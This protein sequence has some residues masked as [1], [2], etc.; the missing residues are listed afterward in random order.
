MTPVVT[1]CESEPPQCWHHDKLSAIAQ[2]RLFK[3]PT[4]LQ[5]AMVL[6]PGIPAKDQWLIVWTVHLQSGM[7]MKFI[8]NRASSA[9]SFEC[10]VLWIK[11]LSWHDSKPIKLHRRLCPFSLAILSKR[12][13][14]HAS[15]SLPATLERKGGERRMASLGKKRPSSDACQIDGV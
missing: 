5:V 3:V 4:K 12:L 2:V 8:N 13:P 1:C 9:A 15:C 6:Q 7:Q 11:A 10:Q 14:N